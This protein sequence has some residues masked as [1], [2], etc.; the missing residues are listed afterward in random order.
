MTMND[1]FV[2]ISAPAFVK[3]IATEQYLF[4]DIST[5]RLPYLH[6][7]TL[8][9]RSSL[10]FSK[11]TALYLAPVTIYSY[12]ITGNFVFVFLN[13]YYIMCWHMQLMHLQQ[14]HRRAPHSCPPI[15]GLVQ[16]YNRAFRYISKP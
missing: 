11:E 6:L 13:A 7:L 1:H 2:C 4:K 15:C 10:Y 12:F 9:Q 14:L 16:F 3:V 8:F 5:A